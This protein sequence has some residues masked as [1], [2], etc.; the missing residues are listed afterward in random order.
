[1]PTV[2]SLV[3]GSGSPHGTDELVLSHNTLDFF[4]IVDDVVIVFQY[5]AEGA[6]ALMVVF[7]TM[8]IGFFYEV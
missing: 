4:A 3:I 5:H 2:F 7:S 6:A 8:V 1:M